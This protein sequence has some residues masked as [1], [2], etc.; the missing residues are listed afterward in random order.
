MNKQPKLSSKPKHEKL[1]WPGLKDEDRLTRLATRAVKAAK[2]RKETELWA[3]NQISRVLN[4]VSPET[5]LTFLMRE[6][7]QR[8]NR[9][10]RAMIRSGLKR[11][12]RI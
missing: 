8:I 1:P 12:R 7:R 6:T 10:S 3:Q 2:E 4:H 5:A 11:T 9:A